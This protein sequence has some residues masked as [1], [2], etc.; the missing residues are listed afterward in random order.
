[1]NPILG[2]GSTTQAVAV[3]AHSTLTVVAVGFADGS[4]ILHLSEN[5]LK[6]KVDRVLSLLYCGDVASALRV[7][8]YTVVFPSTFCEL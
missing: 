1:M 5:V 8:W 7:H 2:P 3:A 6:T 4:V